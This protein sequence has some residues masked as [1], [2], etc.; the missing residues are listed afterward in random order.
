MVNVMMVKYITKDK[1]YN[2]PKLMAFHLHSAKM[3]VH[4]LRIKWRQTYKS[5]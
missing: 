1:L 4:C 3:F 2:I 5:A